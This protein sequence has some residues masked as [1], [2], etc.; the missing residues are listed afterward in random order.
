VE[1]QITDPVTGRTL[2]P[3]A[4]GEILT[5]GYHVQELAR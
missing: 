1:V 4:V 3:G 5:R 2:L